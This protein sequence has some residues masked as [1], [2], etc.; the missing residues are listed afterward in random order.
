[1]RGDGLQALWLIADSASL[2]NASNLLQLQLFQRELLSN[3]MLYDVSAVSANLPSQT[4]L[5]FCP[6]KSRDFACYPKVQLHQHLQNM[7][8][9]CAI[10]Q[11]PSQA[12]LIWSELVLSHLLVYGN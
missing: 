5:R 1:M 2:R 12:V 6:V 9:A 3:K 7:G 11:G 8:A 4:K 10:L